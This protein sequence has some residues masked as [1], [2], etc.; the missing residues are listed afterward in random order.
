MFVGCN[1]ASSKPTGS[2]FDSPIGRAGGSEAPAA[3]R[4]HH[5][6][7]CCHTRN[8]VEEDSR[9]AGGARARLPTAIRG[10]WAGNIPR[11][12]PA[13]CRRGSLS[14]APGRPPQGAA[15]PGRGPPSRPRP[16][17]A[18]HA[19]LRFMLEANPGLGARCPE[20]PRNLCAKLP[21]AL[22]GGRRSACRPPLA[23]SG[24]GSGQVRADD[25]SAHAFLVAR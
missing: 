3:L 10:S 21:G 22:P 11:A 7:L 15:S 5:L 14:T 23:S 13:P 20:G 6:A 18:P 25:R 19:R 8:R 16:C 17:E 2:P 24:L 12:D 9:W 4:Q 1:L